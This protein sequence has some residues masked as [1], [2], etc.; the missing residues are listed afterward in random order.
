MSQR[1]PLLHDH[2]PFFACC[3]DLV[4]GA[5]AGEEV[6]VVVAVQRQV[7]DAGVGV[8]GLLGA[9]AMVN[10]LDTH[11]REEEDDSSHLLVISGTSQGH[12][13]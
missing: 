6:S 3:S 4:R 13:P 12:W 7:E 1:A 2:T 9:V 11:S 5:A 10:I 8:E